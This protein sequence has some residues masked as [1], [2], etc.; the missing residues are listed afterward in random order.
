MKIQPRVYRSL[1]SGTKSVKRNKKYAE[2]SRQHSL[3]ISILFKKG[4]LSG[5]IL[6]KKMSIRR[7]QKNYIKS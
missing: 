5:F 7:Q 6:R 4:W 2:T 3:K 1:T